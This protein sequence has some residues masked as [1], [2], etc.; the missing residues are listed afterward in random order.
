MNHSVFVQALILGF[1]VAAPIGPI[2][3][4]CI[5]RTLTA[6]Y[7]VGLAVGVGAT[8]ADLLFATVAVFGLAATAEALVALQVP[9]RWLG[10]AVLWFLA[11]RALRLEVA[12]VAS[13]RDAVATTAGFLTGFGLLITNPVAILFFASIFA[14]LGLTG[15]EPSVAN[16]VAV[17]GGV[18]LGGTAWWAILAGGVSVFRDRI[19]PRALRAV[20]AL[21]AVLLAAF[22]VV[23]ALS[24][25]R[26]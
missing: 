5:R 23:A 25:A 11:V 6:G 14:G 26:G 17:L 16:T 9:L 3:V 20:N 19:G 8:V 12:P 22:G 2:G 21:S 1:S 10:A 24:A 4:L 7:A 13:R 15:A 18:F